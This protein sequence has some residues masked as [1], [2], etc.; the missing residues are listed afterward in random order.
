M[1]DELTTMVT[2]LRVLLVDIR[3]NPRRYL[4]LSIF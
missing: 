2:E 3:E 1:A 4:R